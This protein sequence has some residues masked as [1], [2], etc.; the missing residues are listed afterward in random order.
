MSRRPA[1]LTAVGGKPRGRQIVWETIRRLRRFTVKQLA[2]EID[3]L[4]D[5][6]R[7]YVDCLSAG[8]FI[9]V[10]DQEASANNRFA[11][12]YEL[13]RDIGVEAPRLQRDGTPCTQGRAREQMWRT[14]KLLDSFTP[15]ELAISASTEEQP[16]NET[17]AGDYVKRLH[18]AGYLTLTVPSTPVRQARY[19][20]VK[21]RNTGPRPPMVQ[22]LKTVFDPN[23]GQIVWHE[24]PAE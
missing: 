6:V 3:H 11:K 22:R 5:S 14:M 7:T 13:V 23:L 21:A 20:F 4:P 15:R 8:G 1:H 2:A 12:V 17:D 24:E 16:V 18:K 9:S 19:R 10:V